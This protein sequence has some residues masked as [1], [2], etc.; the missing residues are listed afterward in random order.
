MRN[1]AVPFALLVL[2]AAA[3]FA[4]ALWHPFSPSAPA[5]EA[6]PG[7][8]GKGASLYTATCAG[9]H[10]ADGSGDVGPALRGS[11]LT[12]ADV[13]SVVTTGRGAMPAGLAS[14]QDLADVAAYVAALSE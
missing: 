4:L 5:A 6:R 1:P 8:A 12:V 2:V 11:G 10:G 13:E 9:C 7:N 14:G 3:T